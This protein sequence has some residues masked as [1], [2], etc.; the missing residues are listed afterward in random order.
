MTGAPLNPLAGIVTANGNV[1]VTVLDA[2]PS[3]SSATLAI[4]QP[5]NA[6]TGSV[7]MTSVGDLT[8]AAS[9]SV[10]GGAITLATLGNFTN[11]AGA[12]ALTA[13]ASGQ[14]LVYSTNPTADT[15]GGLTPAFIQYAA[16]YPVNT[17]GSPTA[18]DA[19]G[20]GF[21][22]SV[23]PQVTVSSV[24]KIYD[25]TTSLPTSTAAYTF[26]GG[27]NGDSVALN[28]SGVSGSYASANV[29]SGIDVTLTG[30]TVTATNNGIPV[31]GY[32]VAA[33]NGGAI[34]TINPAVLT[35]TITGNPSKV[36]DGTSA[37]VLASSNYSLGGFVSGQGA[38][39]TQTAGTY[40][41]ANVGSGIALS[42]SLVASNFAANSGTLLSNY[43]LPTLAM[44]AGTITPATLTAAI[45]NNPSKVYD[46][47][48]A[49]TLATSNFSLSGF[50][51]GQGASVTQTAGTY[52]TANAGTGIAV[53]TSL[54]AANIA[55]NG[56]TL[57]SNY[58][59]PTLATG[60]GTIT[61][62][63]LTA[64][65]VNNPSKVYDGTNTALLASSNYSLGRFVNGDARQCDADDGELCHG[66]R[67]ERNG[68]DRQSRGR[69]LHGEQRDAAVELRA[70]DRRRGH[71]NDHAGDADGKPHRLGQ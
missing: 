36:Y 71:G 66:E 9:G 50:A 3:P 31:Y 30:V 20:N 55:A 22:Y 33:A 48:T 41:T 16:T 4:N 24:T 44:G 58:I 18:P 62:A 63:T 5:V 17:A 70:T 40:A 2:P 34:G 57:L 59:L 46:G 60:T 49:A 21:L 51:A 69:E 14:W 27:F 26:G 29:A 10:T 68:G 37:A 61:P 15:D 64:T 67:G 6:G 47:T 7:T 23:A 13:G 43:V 56:G 19:S 39:V 45:V 25:G 53:S 54:T 1:S 32:G 12:N 65:I 38:S 11:N 52:A 35:A 28:T 42:A 8:I